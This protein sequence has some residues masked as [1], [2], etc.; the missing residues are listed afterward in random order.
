MRLQTD[1]NNGGIGIS[2]A[3]ISTAPPVERGFLVGVQ[4][5]S[6]SSAWQIEDSLAELEQLAATA[7]LEVV[8]QTY[9]KLER[10]DPGTYIGKGK[11]DEIR[12]WLAELQF[13]LLVFDDELSPRQQRNI[14]EFLGVRVLD[15]TALILD[16][17]AQHAHTR[18]GTMQVELAQYE[19]LLPRL[20]HQW[21]HLNRQV[22]AGGGRRG[23][24]SRGA[25][26]GPGSLG[27]GLRGP[28]ETQLETDRREI[29]HKITQLK[30]NLEQVRTQRELYRSQ[31]RHVGIP[32]IALVGYTNA[33]KS[34]L[35][36]ALS[37]ADAYIA[38]QLFATLDPIT[39]RVSLPSG[40]EVLL[41][42]TVGFIKKL[43]T[44]L[45]A[46][47][48]ATLEEVTDADVLLHVVDITQRT[49]IEQSREVDAVLEQLEAIAK[50]TIVVLNK[51]DK[52]GAEQPVDDVVQA[53]PDGLPVS[54][55][56]RTGLDQLLVKIEE[57]LQYS[58]ISVKVKLPYRDAELVALFHKHGSVEWEE[59]SDDGTT[60]KGFLPERLLDSFQDYLIGST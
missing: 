10:I 60:I 56:R 14:E 51:I 6:D 27:A 50:P 48:R 45:V 55:Q 21:A 54:A 43:P 49:A 19:Y 37:G 15:R 30:R 11:L 18:E 23:R 22:A 5:K 13:D 36:N 31:R 2:R 34:T 28:G 39:R 1:E 35:L 17:F 4:L 53:F 44:H 26:S 40:R 57:T 8:G 59:Y 25:G 9:Q 41:T 42:D 32:T 46:A 33:G 29:N 52:L 7:Q 12:T 38:D 20:T 58:M 16:I 24:G 47:F 3:P